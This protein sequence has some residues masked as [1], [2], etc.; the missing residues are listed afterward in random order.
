MDTFMGTTMTVHMVIGMLAGTITFLS[1]PL[2][3]AAIV[4]GETKPHVLTWVPSAIIAGITLFLYDKVGGEETI[5][6]P[7]GDFVGLS[8]IAMLTLWRGERGSIKS[9]EIEDW[10]CAAIAMIGLGIYVAFDNPLIAFGASMVAEVFALAPTMRKTIRFPEQEDFVAWTFTF[11]GNALNFLAMNH[12][13]EIVYVVVI[14]TADGIIWALILK[15]RMKK[16]T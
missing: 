3:M 6:A 9:I 11:C 5:Y 4:R 15:G 2:Y 12:M 14:F 8:I 13:I 1:H 16:R 10:F 7:L